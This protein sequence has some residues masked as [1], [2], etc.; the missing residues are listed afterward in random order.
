LTTILYDL[1]GRIAN[2]MVAGDFRIIEAGTTGIANFSDIL[3]FDSQRGLYVFS[4]IGETV[5]ADVG[6]PFSSPIAPTFQD[7]ERE[8][9]PGVFGYIYTPN[10]GM[11]GFMDGGV[12]YNFIS[13]PAGAGGEVP[14]P[15]TILVMALPL[16][17]ILLRRRSS[18]V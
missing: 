12:T 8:L 4:D 11:P 14:E 17:G 15:A 5:L 16:A 1:P 18:R 9:T 3:R 7:F 13:E 6:L 10:P 2:N